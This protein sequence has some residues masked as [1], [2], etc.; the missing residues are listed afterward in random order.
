MACFKFSLV[1]LALLAATVT[2]VS[3]TPLE[4]RQTSN[5]T[6]SGGGCNPNVMGAGVSIVNTGN[7]K[8]EWG[9]ASSPPAVNDQLV[10]KSFRGL[11]APDWHVQQNGQVIPGYIIKDVDNNNL[12]VTL[13][14]KKKIEL[15]TSSDS[16]TAVDQLWSITCKTCSPDALKGPE[17][18]VG[19]ECTI[20]PQSAENLCVE[21]GSRAS[22]PLSLETC[23]GRARQSFKIET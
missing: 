13:Q 9:V 16:G 7:S 11:S 8:L 19:D 5:S 18:V 6:S 3:G 23:N 22:A 2:D 1:V 21:I 15:G 10:S 14:Q 4:L 20:S 12:A 17:V